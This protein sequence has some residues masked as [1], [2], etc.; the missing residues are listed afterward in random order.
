MKMLQKNIWELVEKQKSVKNVKRERKKN[1]LR[2]SEENLDK[3]KF[4]SKML[5]FNYMKCAI[6]ERENKRK[7]LLFLIFFFVC[8][9]MAS[10]EFFFAKYFDF[11]SVFVV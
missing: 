1:Q 4:V 3:L 2:K 7:F 11:F 5:K 10:K 6:R 8:G 9:A